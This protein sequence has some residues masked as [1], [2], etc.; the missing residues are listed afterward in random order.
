MDVHL[1]SPW[2]TEAS[3]PQL[4]RF[5]PDGQPPEEPKLAE[6]FGKRV[7]SLD[8]DIVRRPGWISGE[9]K[10][11]SGHAPPVID[12]MLATTAKGRSSEGWALNGERKSG[13]AEAWPGAAQRNASICSSDAM[14]STVWPGFSTGR[15]EINGRAEAFA[16]FDLGAAPGKPLWPGSS[17]S[18]G[19]SDQGKGAGWVTRKPERSRWCPHGKP[20][21]SA[22]V[23]N[24]PGPM[25]GLCGA[26]INVRQGGQVKR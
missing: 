14:R 2:N 7:L 18:A 10:R 4:P 20:A 5:R 21:R 24:A 16:V 26:S 15:L 12:T 9:V 23:N 13:E 6:R 8:D 22:G 25:S 17:T 1:V 19:V 11:G 3:Q